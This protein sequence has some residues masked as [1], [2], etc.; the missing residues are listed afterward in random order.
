MSAA[1]D[2][3]FAPAEYAARRSRVYDAIG[4]ACGLVVGAGPER[5]YRFFR[6]TNELL[7]LCGVSLPQC[8]LLLDGAARASTLF[9]PRRG[10]RTDAGEVLGAQDAELI[11]ATMGLERVAP[12]DELAAALAGRRV[13]YTPHAPGETEMTCRWELRHGDKLIADD[14][15]DG[16]PNR[17]QRLIERLSADHEVR[18]LTPLLDEL[19]AV[20]SPGE[21]ELLRRAGDLSARAAEAAMRAT[22]PGL[23]EY[24]L[25]AIALSL[26]LHGGAQGHG[27]R[28]IIACGGNIWF[29]HYWRCQSE[30][31]DGDWVLFDAAPDVDGYTS[32]IGRMWPINGRYSPVQREL[33]GFMVRYH[34]AV[35]AEIRPGRTVE[36]IHASAAA[37]MAPVVDQWRWSQPVYEQAA[38]RVLTFTGHCSH[39]VGMSVHDVYNY[40]QRPLVPGDVF[41]VDPQLWVPEERVYVRCE[42]TVAVTEDGIENLTAAAPLELDEVEALVG[43]G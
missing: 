37:A 24:D 32:D 42:D 26:Y 5:G 20:K 1:L 33:Y 35:L 9:L 23:H 15:W 31:T 28:P 29:N 21:L 10:D 36:E 2:R 19:R 3:H 40:T 13:V 18:D 12:L 41:A 16:L 38:R 11:C 27:Y 8:Y 30:L 14:P 43:R 39:P 17:E 34:Q 7:H 22:R 4:D 25:G 6:Q